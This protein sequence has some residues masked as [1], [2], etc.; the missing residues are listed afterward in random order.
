[1]GRANAFATSHI[2]TD[3]VLGSEQRGE[4]NAGRVINEINA[5]ASLLVPAGL[6]RDETYAFSL[7]E[8]KGI[9]QQNRYARRYEGGRAVTG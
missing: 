4:L 8:V 6:V 7:N 5:A 2:P 3:T 1:D 9:A